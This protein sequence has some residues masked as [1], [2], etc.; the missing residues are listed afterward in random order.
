MAVCTVHWSVYLCVPSSPGTA[1]NHAWWVHRGGPHSWIWWSP[2][3]WQ[4]MAD[5][6]EHQVSKV[7]SPKYNLSNTEKAIWLSNK[8]YHILLY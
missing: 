5:D 4:G 2:D 1:Y 3:N 7:I 6:G 8:H